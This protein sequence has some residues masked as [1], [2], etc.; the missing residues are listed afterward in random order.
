MDFLN[1]K[2]IN[3][4]F[5]RTA[6]SF[7]SR[8]LFLQNLLAEKTQLFP[9]SFL[10]LFT[11]WG[12]ESESLDISFRLNLWAVR[13]LNFTQ[14][15]QVA[16]CISNGLPFSQELCFKRKIYI[17]HIQNSGCS[18]RW[19]LFKKPWSGRR[20]YFGF[21]HAITYICSQCLLLNNSHLHK[22]CKGNSFP[23][24]KWSS[25]DRL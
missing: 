8:I 10:L 17:Q 12:V 11:L 9:F 16:D 18:N 4:L 19:R 22:M 2:K 23:A 3:L 24:I 20:V 25:C 21:H 6:H 5:L 7:S 14:L 1:Q 15:E 13:Q